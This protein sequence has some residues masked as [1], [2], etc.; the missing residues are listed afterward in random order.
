MHNTKDTSQ[1]SKLLLD[2]SKLRQKKVTKLLAHASAILSSSLHYEKTLSKVA[3][4]VVPH[5]ADWCVIHIV[6]NDNKTR[7]VVVAH[8]DPKKIASVRELQQRYPTDNSDH[9]G[10]GKVIKTGKPDMLT[11]IPEE[12]L[13]ASAKDAKHLELIRKLSLKSYIC[14]PLKVRSRVLGAI[15]LVAA[16]SDYHYEKSDLKLVQELARIAAIAVD[17]SLLYQNA[18]DEIVMRKNAESEIK[19]LN[20]SL[21]EKVK[22]R[23]ELLYK[24]NQILEQEIRGKNRIEKELRLLNIK[25]EQSNRDLQ[26]FAQIASHDLQEPLRKVQSFSDRLVIKYADELSPDA[27]DYIQRMQH[28][29]K[30]M[31]TLIN[32]LLTFSRVTTKNQPF[33][34]INL[35][36]VINDVLIDLETTIEDTKAIIH[37]PQLPALEADPLQMRQLFQNIISNA[38]KFHRPEVSPIISIAAEIIKKRDEAYGHLRDYCKITIKD[39]GIG[40]DEKYAEQIFTVFQRLHSQQQFAGTGVGLAVCRR[41]VE[42]HQGVIQAKSTINSGSVFTIL[43]PLTQKK[44][45]D[46]TYAKWPTNQYS[47]S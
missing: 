2:N 37:V 8:I 12:L 3:R 17:N 43:L 36:T 28:A 38:I 24:T 44:G 11:T 30:R 5:F 34:S 39:N 26:D 13:I 9:T 42:R 6:G 16:E 25:L 4:L 45:G 15:T 21:E 22:K 23:T 27:R 14:V 10:V 29:A 31:Q 35:H 41:I 1:T 40:F 46:V 32:D 20:A 19:K 18:K 47:F 7:E 33:N